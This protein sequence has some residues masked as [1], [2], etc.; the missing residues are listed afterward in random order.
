M[1]IFKRKQKGHIGIDFG[2]GG[3]KIIQ[4]QPGDGRGNLFTYGFSERTPEEMGVDYIENPEA[5]AALLKTIC[6]K[7]RTTTTSA[8]AAL[9]IP[10]VFSA[11]LSIAPVPKKEL[12]KAVEWEAKKLIPLP[13]EEVTLDFKELRFPDEET[14][15]KKTFGE[16]QISVLLTAAPKSVIDKYV[17]I[18]KAAGLTLTSLETEAFALI[19]AMVG[20]DPAPVIIVDMGAVRSNILFVDRGI[21]M[22]IRSVEIGG[23]K[24][25]EAIASALSIDMNR[26]EAMKRDLGIAPLPGSAPGQMPTLLK[27][28]LTPLLNE[29]KYSF[30]VYRTR[31]VIARPP[32]KIILSGGGAGLPGLSEL[33]TSE[34]NIKSFLGNPWERVNFQDDLIPLLYTFGSRFAVAIGL[35]LR[36]A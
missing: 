28:V 27:D 26:A 4:L 7:A 12:A 35:A 19:R 29:M 2:A 20:V 24:C 8:V 30:N 1:S 23:K 34:F 22:L 9:P 21:P 6:S 5:T 25:T 15:A 3:I 11:V 18:A 10:T 16:K 32:E 31:S 33:I 36:N 14:T 17:A 13:L